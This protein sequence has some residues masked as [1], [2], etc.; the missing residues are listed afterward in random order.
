MVPSWKKE[1]MKTSPTSRKKSQSGILTI[2]TKQILTKIN[3]NK[4]IINNKY[5]LNLWGF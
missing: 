2:N 5:S 4:N 3:T 1:K